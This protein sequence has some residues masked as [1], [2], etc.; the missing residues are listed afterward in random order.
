MSTQIQACETGGEHG[1]QDCIDRMEAW[2]LRCADPHLASDEEE[3]KR[4]AYGDEEP[5]ENVEPDE[6][7]TILPGFDH[8]EDGGG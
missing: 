7:H 8:H 5:P 1:Q 2:G 4:H 6:S 3:W